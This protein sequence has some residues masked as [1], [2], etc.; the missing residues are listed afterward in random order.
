MYVR[1]DCKVRALQRVTSALQHVAVCC[2]VYLQVDCKVRVEPAHNSAH[3]RA[4][5]AACCS[6]LQH[7]ATHYNIRQRTR[8][9][10]L[11]IVLMFARTLQC[12]AEC[13][14]VL[15]DV[16]AC[17]SVLQRV[18]ACCS[19]TTCDPTMSVWSGVRTRCDAACCR[20]FLG[21][22]GCCNML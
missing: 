15:Q 18:A 8:E 10:Q 2:S 4:C 12:V 5:V 22:A 20:E 7:T 17:C 1:V 16:A 19:C 14:S 11:I 6:V 13:C 3:V 21:V 9:Y